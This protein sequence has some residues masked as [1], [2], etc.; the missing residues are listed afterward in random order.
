[1]ARFLLG[2]FLSGCFFVVCVIVAIF[3]A[4]SHMQF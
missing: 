1:V 3:Q 2:L 4:C